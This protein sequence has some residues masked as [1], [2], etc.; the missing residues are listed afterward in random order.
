[1]KSESKVQS[2]IMKYIKS[3]GWYVIKVVRANE[4]G[5]ND[6]LACVNGRF[7]SIEVKAEKFHKDPVK[8]ASEWQKRHM[9]LVREANGI[10]MCVASLE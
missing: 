1:M 9:R 4:S 3:F 6:L 10:S 2:E 5:V 8:Q 7:V